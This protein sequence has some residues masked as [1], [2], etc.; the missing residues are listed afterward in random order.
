MLAK[1]S[2]SPRVS[3]QGASSLTPFASK[4]APTLGRVLPVAGQ[5]P[6]YFLAW[7]ECLQTPFVKHQQLVSLGQRRGPM[8]DQDHTAALGLHLHNGAGQGGFADGVEVGVGFIE[9]NQARL[10]IQCTGQGH[11]LFLATGQAAAVVAQDR[12]IPVGQA[13]DQFMHTGLL[14]SLH[15]TLGVGIA[16]ARDVVG[17]AA[18]E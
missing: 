3:N 13:Q 9:H 16:K 14:R 7:P 8:G 5:R 10:A 6:Q 12:V 11:P 1:N 4:L 2:P 18:A 17:N 15:H